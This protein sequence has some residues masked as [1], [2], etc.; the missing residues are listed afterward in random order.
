MCRVVKGIC[1]GKVWGV[2]GCEMMFFLFRRVFIV[3]GLGG[4]IFCYY[5][6]F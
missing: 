2:R 3:C 5:F 1:E 4:A 6:S